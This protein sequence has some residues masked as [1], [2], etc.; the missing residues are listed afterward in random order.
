MDTAGKILDV[1]FRRIPPERMLRRVSE[2][3]ERAFRPPSDV[4]R[5]TFLRFAETTLQGYSED[6]QKLFFNQLTQ[7]VRRRAEES[8][9]RESVFLPLVD[10]GDEV[11]TLQG[12]EPLCR[13][14][15]VL[16]WRE[17][18]H[19]F[20]QDMV[21]CAYLAYRDGRSGIRRE[22][23]AWPAVLPTDNGVLRQGL[24]SGIAENHYHLNGSTQSFALAWCALMNDPMAVE[25]LPEGFSMLLQSVASR[26]PEDNVLS[27]GE[28]LKVAALVRSILFRALHRDAFLPRDA[29]G[30]QEKFCSRDVF[31]DEYLRLFEPLPALAGQV[32]VLQQGYGMVFTLPE[33]ETACLD[34]ALGPEV[35]RAVENSPYRVLAG[36]RHFLYRCFTACFRERFTDFEQ[37]LFYLYLLLKTAFRGEMIQVNRQVGFQNFANYQDRKDLAWQGPYRWEACRMALNAPLEAEHV[38]FLEGRL[39]PGDTAEAMEERIRRYDLGKR[40]AD[41]PFRPFPH[42]GGYE[43]DPELEA[44]SFLGERHF[45]VVHF[46]KRGDEDPV[47]LPVFSRQCRH[48]ALREKT[49]G[50]ALALAEGLS[51][52]PYLCNRVRGID[53]CSNEVDCR[54]EVFATAFRFLRNF[55]PEEFGSPGALL[56]QPKHRLSVTY[57]AGEDFYDIADGLRAIDEAVDFLDFRRGDR[58]G[59]ALALGVDPQ[60]HYRTKAMNIILPK[61]NYL[62][63]LVWLL[64]R[65]RELGVRIDPQQYGIM[66]RD[67]LR[68]MREIYGRMDHHWSM[69]LQD[70]YCSMMLRGDAPQLYETG[71]F[72]EPQANGLQYDRWQVAPGAPGKELGPYRRDQD[73]AALYSQYHYG[74]EE[75]IEGAK[76]VNIP[77]TA[78]YIELVRQVQEAMQRYLERRGI[79]I[80]CNPSSNVLIG[81]IGE[82]GKHP[83]VRFNNAALGDPDHRRECPQLHVCINTDDLGVFDTSL[84]FEY[85]LLFRALGEQKDADGRRRYSD[86]DIYHYLRSIQEMGLQ[87]VFPP[88]V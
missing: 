7:S 32:K 60:I 57:H 49:K 16:R 54:P 87:A 12:E 66:Q 52:S 64:Y 78:D 3:A 36:E 46:P 2:H 84:E 28:R 47:K 83:I 24:E 75:K 19:L 58:I 30:R 6:E 71:A 77:I 79:M 56:P 34:Y 1:L 55:R 82:Y 68:L 72:Q 29:E 42:L 8:G 39:T 9:L 88:P 80:E 81:T 15:Q 59:H 65:G 41:E 21:V 35:F 27:T 45:Y 70:Y 31:R 17:L 11:L 63:N 23:F 14:S 20:G 18:Y 67:A 86:W 37:E 25:E 40:F 33:G 74:R 53:A 61:Q 4:R 85:A 51:R 73:I 38:R 62:D 48:E 43:F 44:A 26:G 13:F 5:S 50:Q 69:T 22:R 76:A 10:L